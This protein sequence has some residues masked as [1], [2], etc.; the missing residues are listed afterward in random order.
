VLS[1]VPLLL[2]PVLGVANTLYTQIGLILMTAL[3]PRRPRRGV[4]A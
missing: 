3:S 4:K 2:G 1:A